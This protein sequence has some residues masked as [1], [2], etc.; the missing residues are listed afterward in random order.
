MLMSLVKYKSI[1]E[2]RMI[3]QDS[4]PLIVTVEKLILLKSLEM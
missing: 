2:L 4:L 1:G 3:H